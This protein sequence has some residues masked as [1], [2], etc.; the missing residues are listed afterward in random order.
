M[1]KTLH[2][3]AKEFAEAFT[4]ET[5]TDGSKY[6]TLNDDKAEWMQEAVQE[7][8]TLGEH[9]ALPDDSIYEIC[10]EVADAIEE[11]LGAADKDLEDCRDLEMRERIDGLV[12]VYTSDLKHWAFKNP[13]ADEWMQEAVDQG[14]IDTTAKE[15]DLDN[16]RMAGYYMQA[17]SICGTFLQAIQDQYDDQDFTIEGEDH[18]QFIDEDMD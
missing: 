6:V 13:H 5:R 17:D 3:I 1:F 4:T 15:F 7:A 10:R 11:E 12:P 2:E 18:D 9:L 14:L 16:L 8:H